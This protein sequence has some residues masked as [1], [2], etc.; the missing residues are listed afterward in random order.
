LYIL[1]IFRFLDSRKILRNE[2]VHNF[3]Y[4]ITLV[5]AIKWCE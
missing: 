3:Q 5:L 4:S 1:I 2:E